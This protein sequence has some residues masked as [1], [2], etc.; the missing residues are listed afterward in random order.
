MSLFQSNLRKQIENLPK[1]LKCVNIIHYNSLLFIRVLSQL[2]L[3]GPIQDRRQICSHRGFGLLGRRNLTASLF[4]IFRREHLGCAV[5]AC[6]RDAIRSSEFA[7]L[8]RPA[9]G[10][11]RVGRLRERFKGVGRE[12]EPWKVRSQLY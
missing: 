5:V 10:T 4:R 6:L 2:S 11:T 12:Q 8:V 1:I 9:S 7:E 3:S